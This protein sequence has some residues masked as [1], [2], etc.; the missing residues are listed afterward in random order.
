M[1]IFL[2]TN[3]L[4]IVFFALVIVFCVKLRNWGAVLINILGFLT[5]ASSLY[6]EFSHLQTRYTLVVIMSIVVLVMIFDILIA[7]FQL[8]TGGL[9]AYLKPMAQKDVLENPE[10]K[11][12]FDD[13]A[14]RREINLNQKEEMI[15]GLQAY[16]MWKMGNKAYL[17]GDY[18]NAM[19][20]YELSLHWEASS[21]AWVNKSGVCI[22]RG[23]FDQAI[24]CCDEAIKLNDECEEAWI[25]RGVS[26]DR[27][28][29]YDK[30]IKSFDKALIVNESNPDT[31]T[32][33][34]NALRRLGKLEE[35]LQSYDKAIELKNDQLAAWYNKGVAFSKLGRIEEAVEC[36]SQVVK[37]QPDFAFGYYNL[38]NS[39]NKLDRN[40]EALDAY[41]HA[42][43][44][45]PRFNEAWNNQGI[46]LSKIGQLRDAIKSY[47]RAIGIKPDYY[48]AWINRALALESLGEI[49]EAIKS[50]EKFLELAPVELKKH[51][52]IAQRHVEEL[53]SRLAKEEKEQQK[54]KRWLWNP[55]KK[56]KTLETATDPELGEQTEQV[57]SPE[58]VSPDDG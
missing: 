21:V 32:Y 12:I 33:H 30:A 3:L 38:G 17:A 8:R 1:I 26:F 7:I 34:G 10:Y 2:F 16:E 51:I 56:E 55:F 45:Q 4:L 22:E 37:I 23:N 47:N 46:A 58:T 50:Y 36:F 57:D 24:H 44:L 53:K 6:L 40:K 54:R 48:E 14:I 42:L 20:K 27:K 43:R 11:M 15:E 25:N 31:W 52:A 18:D 19:E 49:R 13:A 35:S 28:R 39:Y 41:A 9:Y 29:E 5:V